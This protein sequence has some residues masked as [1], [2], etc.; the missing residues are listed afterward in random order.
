MSK[1]A[2][3]RSTASWWDD[4]MIGSTSPSWHA[5]DDELEQVPQ[6]TAPHLRAGRL[7]TRMASLELGKCFVDD[8]I[9]GAGKDC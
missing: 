1:P 2:A 3:K 8:S 4:A 9:L 6:V 5:P 7:V